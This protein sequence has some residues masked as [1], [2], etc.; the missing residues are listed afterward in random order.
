[1]KIKVGTDGQDDPA[2]LARF[3]KNPRPP[4]GYPARRKR[5]LAA[6]ELC[7]RVQPLVQFNPTALEQP[8]PHSEVDCPGRAPASPGRAGD[9]RRVALRLSRRGRGRRAE[10]GRSIERATLQ[11][12]RHLALAPDHGAGTIGQA[13]EFSSAATPARPHCSRRP[14]AT[15]PAQIPVFAMSKA[16]MTGT[17]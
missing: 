4:H 3:E 5:G 14:A 10:N 12:R 13:W 7:D 15:L 11:V 17:S 9:A 2:R 16:R 8:V 6:G 1:M